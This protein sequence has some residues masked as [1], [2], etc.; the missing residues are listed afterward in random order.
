MDLRDPIWQGFEAIVTITGVIFTIIFFIAPEAREWLI[1]TIRS[2]AFGLLLG[3]L[4]ILCLCAAFLI[5]VTKG[6]ASLLAR[7][8][9][10]NTAIPLPTIFPTNTLNPSTPTP[11][12][13]YLV[14]D[15][16]NTGISDSWQ[17]KSGQWQMVNNRLTIIN[18]LDGT[19]WSKGKIMTGDQTRGNYEVGVDVH[20]VNI[21]TRINIAHIIVRAIDDSNY[22]LL[23]I[24]DFDL[25]DSDW[26]RGSWYIVSNNELT[27][28][29][30]AGF[31]SFLTT[32]FSIN[33]Q[34][35][36]D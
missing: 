16:F 22:L 24:R 25:F 13:T 30:N 32:D 33:I 15:D 9:P 34:L 21:E 20:L 4:F 3:G 7:P 12:Y 10:T 17:I 36:N 2:S 19:D 27:E 23:E 1:R 6:V 26:S 35:Q 11:T 18:V 14:I 31:S 8:T 29:S 5:P 28:I